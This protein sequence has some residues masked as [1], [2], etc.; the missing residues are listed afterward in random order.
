MCEKNG[1]MGLGKVTLPETNSSPWKMDG[2]K[3]KSPLGMA[4]LRE[5][6]VSFGECA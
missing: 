2:W 6:T 5:R 1:P 3:M 4:Y